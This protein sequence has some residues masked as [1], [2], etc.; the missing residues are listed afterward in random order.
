MITV[1][2]KLFASLG[3]KFPGHTLGEPLEVQLPDE[4]TLDHL[5]DHLDLDGA[6]VI[7]VNGIAKTDRSVTLREADELAV[8]PLVAGG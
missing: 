8:F 6:N 3:E 1:K 2:V 7:L 4:S 5:I